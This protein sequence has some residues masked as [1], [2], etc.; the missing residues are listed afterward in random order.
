MTGIPASPC[1]LPADYSFQ[2]RSRP[3]SPT[4]VTPKSMPEATSPPTSEPCSASTRGLPI[5][6]R[7]TFAPDS[8][9]TKPINRLRFCISSPK[10]RR[11]STSLVMAGAGNVSI[12][13]KRGS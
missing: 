6:F 13:F 3:S 7:S 8:A 4:T 12:T 11:Q 9:R 10:T 2:V 1:A 5:L